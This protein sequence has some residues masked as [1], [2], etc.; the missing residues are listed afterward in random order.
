MGKPFLQIRMPVERGR[1]SIY[2]LF[3]ALLTLKHAVA[4]ELVH[5]KEGVHLSW[6]LVGVWH[7]AAYKV[8]LTVVQ[9]RTTWSAGKKTIKAKMVEH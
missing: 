3:T 9:L 6:L 5:D 4:S 1:L 7:E 2:L 8:R